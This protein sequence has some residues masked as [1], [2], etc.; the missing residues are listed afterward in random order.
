MGICYIVGAGDFYKPFTPEKDD[1]VIA[2][3]GGYDHLKRFGIYSPRRR[4]ESEMQRSST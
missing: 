4:K 2:A 3:D 1:L